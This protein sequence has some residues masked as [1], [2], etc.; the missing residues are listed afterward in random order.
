MARGDND[1]AEFIVTQTSTA[2]TGEELDQTPPWKITDPPVDKVEKG[3]QKQKRLKSVMEEW[4]ISH[5]PRGDAR[6]AMTARNFRT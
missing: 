4:K 2:Q 3:L 5:C 6:W 1:I